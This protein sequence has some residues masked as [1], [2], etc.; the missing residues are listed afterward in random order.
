MVK[1]T[2]LRKF[3]PEFEQLLF[4]ASQKQVRLT[5]P[6]DKDRSRFRHRF[7]DYMRS[8]LLCGYRPDLE[9]MA[10]TVTI[11]VIEG[12]CLLIGRAENTIESSVIRAALGLSSEELPERA[13]TL[14]IPDV[15]GL[16]HK[17]M[18]DKLVEIRAK[19][20]KRNDD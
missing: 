11:T 9:A 3:P 1:I 5:F 14:P 17:K 18:L 8:V 15:S 20:G 12:K 19:R 13:D 7:Y 16:A 2:D 6:E 4:A 10:A